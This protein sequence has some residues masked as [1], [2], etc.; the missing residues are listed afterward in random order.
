MIKRFEPQYLDEI[1][2]IWLNTN[3]SAH[4]FINKSFW[5]KAAGMVKSLLPSADLFIYQ[6]E[7]I[8]K[9]FIGITDNI[10]IAGLF[11]RDT[12]QSQ[13]IGRK[14]L[15]HCKNMYSHME[16]DVFVENAGAVR[17][18]Q[19]NGFISVETKMNPDFNCNEYHMNW[20]A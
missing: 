17:F 20:S 14:L 13:G 8:I 1:M 5:E 7:N 11:V 16:L 18:Y 6:E 19:K 9:G 12:C 3:I 15:D 10:Y 4:S 2:D